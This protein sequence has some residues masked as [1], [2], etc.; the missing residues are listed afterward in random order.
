MWPLSEGGSQ[1]HDSCNPTCQGLC[2][3]GTQ[4][5]MEGLLEEVMV[6]LRLRHLEESAKP[7]RGCQQIQGRGTKRERGQTLGGPARSAAARAGRL[8][9]GRGQ[10]IQ[11]L[12]P[13]YPARA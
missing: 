1:V 8:A 3:R 2:P 11:G 6:E 9:V 4:G 13:G 10:V 7:R 12:T 5:E